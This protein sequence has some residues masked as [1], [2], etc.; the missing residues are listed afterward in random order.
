MMEIQQNINQFS[1]WWL[2]GILKIVPQAMKD[3]LFLTPDRLIISV[4]NDLIK[5]S[6]LSGDTNNVIDT[7]RI[8]ITDELEKDEGI[9]W[10][11]SFKDK[12][13]EAVLAVPEN[14]L[15][16]KTISLPAASEPELHAVLGFEMD[17][18]TPFT[19]EQ[20]FY[21]HQVVRRDKENDLITV[22]LYVIP[23]RSLEKVIEK[24][25]AISIHPNLVLI[26]SNDEFQPDVNLLPDEFK[27]KTKKGMDSKNLALMLAT[28][29]LCLIA[30][31]GP[32]LIKS[33]RLSELETV[34]DDYR[35]QAMAA[36]PIIKERD[37]ILSRTLF[38]DEKLQENEGNDQ[39]DQ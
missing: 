3:N 8:T 16:K 23:K 35:Q 27:T 26:R 29:L 13:I 10:I 14:E 17:K 39:G 30:L 33:N 12:T 22:N 36:Q 2:D 32:L 5:M 20:V 6:L 21:D 4:E 11:A 1:H 28:V 31:Y 38:L 25:N 7:K 9:K 24:I 19:A 18:Q 37:D 34:V 15:L